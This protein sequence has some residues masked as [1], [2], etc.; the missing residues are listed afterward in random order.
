MA[1]FKTFFAAAQGAPP[2]QSHYGARV[3]V[4]WQMDGNG[5]DP[6][7]TIPGV[8]AN[9]PG[10]GDC[11]VCGMAHSLTIANF[12][13]GKVRDL[14][15]SANAAV[16]TY[17]QLAGCTPAELFSNPDQYDTGLDIST[18]LGV[19]RKSGLF[20]VRGG[21]YAP[22]DH[23]NMDDVKNGLYL[24]GG[25][26]IG[27]QV[28]Q[29]QETQFPGEWRWVPGSPILGGHCITLTGYTTSQGLFWGTTWGTLIPIAESFL[30]NAMDEAYA[31][32]SAQAIAYGR[33][34]TGLN[35]TQLE[36]ALDQ[37]DIAA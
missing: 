21:V 29:A 30:V 12:E 9:W 26:V 11:V 1:D 4:P 31:L 36:A 8:P 33:G 37:L 32:V 13:E 25:L 17:C 16:L 3:T 6:A 7:V 10:C 14:V 2:P 15:P 23:T 27:I 24:G 18:T 20:G 35:I 5:P 22:V 19:W 28:Q 34:P